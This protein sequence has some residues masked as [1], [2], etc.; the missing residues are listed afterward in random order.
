MID[1]AIQVVNYKTKEYLSQCIDSVLADIQGADYTCRLL[2]LENGSGDD[3]EPLRKR[4]AGKNIE[5]HASEVNLGFGGG[6]NLLASKV[7]SKYLFVLNPDTQVAGGAI[8]KMADFMEAQHEAGMCGPRVI[9]PEKNFFWHKWPF[10]PKK[11]IWKEFFERF[12]H[13]RIMEKTAF[14]EHAPIIGSAL[15]IRKDAFE[16]VGGFDE[17]LFLYFEENDLCNALKEKG[18]KIYF[19]YDAVVTHFYGKSEASKKDK[20]REF[21]KSRRYFYKK[22]YG[23]EEARKMIAREENAANDKYL[24]KVL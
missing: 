13:V 2:V 7:Q 3:L 21:K 18:Y 20:V 23:E 11:F 9:L 16:R 12:L 10:W 1:I 15:F 22:W 19:I 14:L 4:Y 5:W 17:N 8:K 6:H 24:E